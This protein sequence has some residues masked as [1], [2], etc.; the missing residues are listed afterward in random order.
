M[1]LKQKAKNLP[2]T[3]GVYIM[4]DFQG[5][6]IYIGK[7]KSLKNRVGQYFQG[8][9]RHAPK[10]QR[11][12]EGMRDF[13]FILADT[14]L[15]ALLLESQL[16]KDLKPIYNSQL[17]NP[18]KYKYIKITM[19]QDYPTLELSEE[20]VEACTCFGPYTSSNNVERA[21]EVLKEQLGIRYCKNLTKRTTG[22]LNSQ[23]GSCVAPCTGE[24]SQAS[25]RQL[26]E[27]AMR[28]LEGNS[29][30]LIDSLQ[31]KMQ[32]A[33]EKLNFLKAAKYRDDIDALKYLQNKQQVISF[34]QSSSCILF[35]EWLGVNRLKFFI[36]KSNRI[37]YKE[38][39]ELH[40]DLKQLSEH[41]LKVIFNCKK[42]IKRYVPE[43]IDKFHIDQAQIIYSYVRNKKR[44][45][46]LT[47][48]QSWFDPK[49]K[50]KLEQ[51]IKKLLEKLT[52]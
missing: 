37:L 34:G 45:K 33:A 22:C 44:V 43:D 12:I 20:R 36:I 42:E 39:C 32:T 23:L 26:I 48:R 11:M 30:E 1:D 5:D 40:S 31:R 17:K 25:Y 24:I 51:G 14:E 38:T 35:A 52:E 13:D 50:L 29:R 28:F 41:M 9:D 21:L 2:E 16:I 46:Y 15:E 3:P 47:L 49:S 8:F 4:K 7:A 19:E 27:Q 18:L 6:I 10:I